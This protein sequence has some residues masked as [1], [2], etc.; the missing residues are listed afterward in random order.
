MGVNMGYVTPLDCSRSEKL[1][2]FFSS[3]S[4]LNSP[5]LIVLEQ[6]QGQRNIVGAADSRGK[7]IKSFWIREEWLESAPPMP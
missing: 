1:L 4:G 3:S 2:A 6:T 5:T 7:A